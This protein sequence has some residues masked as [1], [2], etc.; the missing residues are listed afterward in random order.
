MLYFQFHWYFSK[1]MRYF[2]RKSIIMNVKNK[3]LCLSVFLVI[4]LGYNAC[5]SQKRATASASAESAFLQ[6]CYLIE[7]LYVPSCR[8]EIFYGNQRY[9][10]SGSIYVQSDSVCFFRGRLL[11]E[12][13]RGAIY[14]DSFIV[15]NYLERTYYKGKNTFLENITGFPINPESLMMLFTAD[16]CEEVYRDRFQFVAGNK[17][18]DKIT[19]H[20]ASRSLLEIIL[21]PEDKTVEDISLYNAQQRQPLFNAAY[22]QYR[23]FDQF[24]LP[25]LLEIFA[26]GGFRIKADLQQI[27][28]NQ[29]QQFSINIPSNYRL[30]ILE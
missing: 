13:V 18:Q 4:F 27:V 11:V 30:E 12:I 19:M 15:V 23:Q 16:R 25:T 5:R 24:A 3:I 17:S 6:S 14:R 8:M 26:Q 21:N 20:G 9:S 29:Q 28:L 1:K 10:L 22:S 7:S 2:A